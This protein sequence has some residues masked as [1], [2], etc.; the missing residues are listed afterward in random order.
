MFQPCDFV[1]DR[2]S[3]RIHQARS[4]SAIRCAQSIVGETRSSLAKGAVRARSVPFQGPLEPER[5]AA[6]EFVTCPGTL[7]G[8]QR[9][10]RCSRWRSG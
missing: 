1:E 9:P 10:V 3:R 7:R 6:F 8:T 5:G 2:M 4:C